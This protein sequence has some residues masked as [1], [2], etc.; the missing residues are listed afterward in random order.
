M[1]CNLFTLGATSFAQRPLPQPRSNPTAS[2]G[3]LFQG[4]IEK[5]NWKVSSNSFDDN[6]D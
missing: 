4:K 1:Q 2:E 3:I 5:Y 6:S